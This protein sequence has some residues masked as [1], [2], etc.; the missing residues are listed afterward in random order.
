MGAIISAGSREIGAAPANAFDFDD[1][2]FGLGAGDEAVEPGSEVGISPP[3]N[4]VRFALDF[5]DVFLPYCPCLGYFS[6]ATVTTVDDAGTSSSL[7]SD[8][9]PVVSSAAG[10][11]RPRFV[12]VRLRKE[13]SAPNLESMAWSE[14]A[15]VVPGLACA[16]PETPRRLLLAGESGGGGDAGPGFAGETFELD[17]LSLATALF[18]ARAAC[19][20]WG[21]FNRRNRDAI[22][23]HHPLRFRF[24]GVHCA[25]GA[26]VAPVGVASVGRGKTTSSEV[27]TDKPMTRFV[28]AVSAAIP[29]SRASGT[30]TGRSVDTGTTRSFAASAAS[31]IL[32]AVEVSV[33]PRMDPSTNACFCGL[34]VSLEDSASTISGPFPGRS[35]CSLARDKSTTWDQSVSILCARV[36]GRMKAPHTPTR[37]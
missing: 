21:R 1:F 5:G 30:S 33:S 9:A 13:E 28:A 8:T 26:A 24:P 36:C 11:R 23:A 14:R 29:P 6:A 4:S 31:T 25:G 12:T 20:F 18:V 19:F 37:I 7:L 17:R 15:Y 10:D 32:F 2:G 3:P 22:L 34:I 35:V 27:A 16:G